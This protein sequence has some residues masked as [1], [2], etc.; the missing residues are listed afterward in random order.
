M[1]PG[2]SKYSWSPGVFCALKRNCLWADPLYR[3]GKLHRTVG[4]SKQFLRDKPAEASNPKKDKKYK[5]SNECD[6]H[7]VHLPFCPYLQEPF[8][9]GRNLPFPTTVKTM[10]GTA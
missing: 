10:Y 5:Q 4:A 7:L 2:H 1:W 9:C 8:L 6:Q 3:N